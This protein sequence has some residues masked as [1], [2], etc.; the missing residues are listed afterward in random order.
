[1]LFKKTSAI[2]TYPN[3]NTADRKSFSFPCTYCLKF[4]HPE[5]A[6][7]FSKI[8]T[9]LL[10]YVV[11]FKVE[12]SQK[13]VAFSEYMSKVELETVCCKKQQKKLLISY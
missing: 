8:F 1:M 4:I 12:F 10:S 9:L 6:T 7:K 3:S 2:M 11:P 5:K 13:F